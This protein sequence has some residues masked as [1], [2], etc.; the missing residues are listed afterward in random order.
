MDIGKV[1]LCEVWMLPPDY[2]NGAEATLMVM[3]Y[4]GEMEGDGM[5][6]IVPCGGEE[7]RLTAN[8][9]VQLWEPPPGS[10]L[11][12][13]QLGWKIVPIRLLEPDTDEVDVDEKA[14][15]LHHGGLLPGLRQDR[16][17]E[18]EAVHPE[19]E[20]VEEQAPVLRGL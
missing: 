7:V 6:R 12:A 5:T 17:L 1:Y 4:A 16:R 13:G 15:V 2:C 18:G 20:A 3:R 14:L 11:H 8:S 19:T 10:S 9:T